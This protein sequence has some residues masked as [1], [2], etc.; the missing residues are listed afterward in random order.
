MQ[1]PLSAPA[2]QTAGPIHTAAAAGDLNR[3]RTLL[4]EDPTLRDSR[5]DRDRTPLY[6]AAATGHVEI[7]TFLLDAGAEIESADGSGATPLIGAVLGNHLPVVR[8]LAE[9]GADCTAAHNS[10]GP[11]IDIAFWVECRTGFSGV[12]AYL[13]ERGTPYDP[14]DGGI[15]TWLNLASTFGNLHMAR[16]ALEHGADVNGVSTAEGQSELQFAVRCGSVEIVRLYLEHGAD[17]AAS[18]AVDAPLLRTVVTNGVADIVQLLL[19]YGARFDFVDPASGHTLLHLAAIRGYDDI[20]ILLLTAG[21]EVDPT[22]TRHRTPLYYAVRY[23]HPSTTRL[24]LSRGA[25]PL[26]G[27]VE[28]EAR[29]SLTPLSPAEGEAVA[30]WLDSGGWAIRTVDHMLV[31]NSFEH[32]VAKPARPCLTNGFV[33]A[34][35]VGDQNLYVL[36]TTWHWPDMTEYLHEIE[37]SLA[38]VTYIHNEREAW[39][40]CCSTVYL[41]PGESRDFGDLE[42]QSVPCTYGFMTVAYIIRVDGLTLYYANFSTDEPEKYR[43]DLEVVRERFGPV[44]LA[45][46]PA[47]PVGELAAS[48]LRLVIEV[49]QPAA[50]CLLDNARRTD[51]FAA[52]ARWIGEW[53]FDGEVFGIEN[54]GDRIVYQRPADRR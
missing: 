40:G 1:V 52:T 24:L 16:F 17:V 47:H 2:S 29:R 15:A 22:D 44:D 10:Y 7:V 14:T 45:F 23:A 28:R 49:L 48:D 37:D 25:S 31:I 32:Q 4:A 19:E 41:T 35:E 43:H 39:R 46:L 50:L 12:T 11:A 54:P 36:Y 18:D 3:V 30:W 38:H 20:C 9:R 53:G 42:L 21:A 33:R 6:H 13:I 26:T 34:S 5:D 8:I 51:L 27:A